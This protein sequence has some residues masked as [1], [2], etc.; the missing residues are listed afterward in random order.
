M[1]CCAVPCCVAQ[2]ETYLTKLNTDKA[3]KQEY[4]KLWNE[5]RR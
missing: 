2:V 1:L 4:I 5:Q 3:F